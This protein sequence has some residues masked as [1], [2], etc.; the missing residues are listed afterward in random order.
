MAKD[1]KTETKGKT[2]FE[3]I[4]VEIV[5]TIVDPKVT[6][7]PPSSKTEPYSIRPHAYCHH[8]Y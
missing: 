6:R 7:E 1:T 2:H 5:K 4:P 3:Q 8:A